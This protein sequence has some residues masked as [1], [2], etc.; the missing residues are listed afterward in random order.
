MP[1]RAA[2]SPVRRPH[3]ASQTVSDMIMNSSQVVND[4]ERGEL[5]RAM[6]LAVALVVLPCGCTR[7]AV[8][9]TVTTLCP[10]ASSNCQ[11]QCSTGWGIGTTTDSNCPGSA[12]ATAAPTAP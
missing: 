8:S 1:L 11:F 12:T 2:T 7:A 10:T 9:P 5:I 4:E 6:P 3:C